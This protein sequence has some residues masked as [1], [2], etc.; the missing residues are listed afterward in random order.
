MV[1][2]QEKKLIYLF[3]LF[4]LLLFATEFSKFGSLT[5]FGRTELVGIACVP[6]ATPK[7]LATPA[8]G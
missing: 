7:I 4:V 3:S 2:L 5:E 1:V 8:I 6:V